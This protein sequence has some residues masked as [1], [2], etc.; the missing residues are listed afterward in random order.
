MS[1][2]KQFKDV[3]T[4]RKAADREIGLVLGELHEMPQFKGF[5]LEFMVWAL[6]KVF[7]HERS[8][9][10]F[11]QLLEGNL[12]VCTDKWKDEFGRSMRKTLETLKHSNPVDILMD[13]HKMEV[14]PL[15]LWC[16]NVL[17]QESIQTL[18]SKLTPSVWVDKVED[19]T[20]IEAVFEE[21]LKP[22]RLT[23]GEL[24]QQIKITDEFMYPNTNF[25]ELHFPLAKAHHMASKIRFNYA[26]VKAARQLIDQRIATKHN[27]W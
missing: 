20:R 4:L 19:D 14:S 9:M 12:E 22:L 21:T 13:F 23:A 1:N 26:L 16:I 25:R 24:T 2:D 3:D 27:L 7:S 17:F 8:S 11:A 18:S 10:H 15:H 5:E 6:S